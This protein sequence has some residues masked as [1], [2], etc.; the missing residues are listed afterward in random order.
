MDTDWFNSFQHKLDQHHR[1]PSLYIFKFIVPKEKVEELKSLFPQHTTSEKSS[2][3]GNYVSVTMEVMM[4]SSNAVIGI[5]KVAS[6][7][8]G[9]IAL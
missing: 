7:V 4:P 9:L 1:W 2:T 6:T 8:E 3:K 5:Y